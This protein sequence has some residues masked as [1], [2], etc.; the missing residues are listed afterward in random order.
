METQ[1][2]EVISINIWQIV[3]SLCNL[4]ILFFVLKKF[5]YKPVKKVLAER[6]AAVEKEY[7][8]ARNAS[9]IAEESRM[10]W[11]N[12]LSDADAEAA[13]VVRDATSAAQTRSSEIIA[14]ARER[15]GGIIRE[16]EDEASLAK[17]K[18]QGEIRE[19]IVDVSGCLAE[20]LLEREI[21]EGDHQKLI[22]DFIGD[23]ENDRK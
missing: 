23:L 3:V 15:A 14:E 11:E 2:L 19:E 12:K 16:A 17:K 20:K 7:S 6:S 18:A 8:D 5:L 9:G 13:A 10:K 1:T 4:I 21:N 22:D